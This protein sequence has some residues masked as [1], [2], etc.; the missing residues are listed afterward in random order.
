TLGT[1]GHPAVGWILYAGIVWIWHV[2][3]FYQAALVNEW[4]H[5]FQHIAFMLAALIFWWAALEFGRRRT[6]GY[7]VGV[8]Y[9][10]TTALH[11]SAFGALLTFAREAWYPF[12]E[13]RTAAWGLTALQD[14]QFG[15]LVMWVPAGLVYMAAAL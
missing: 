4:V 7:G 3:R 10:F 14:Q 9:F 1:L 5:V 13:A 15:G 11:G 8:V 2:P 12:Y 6:G